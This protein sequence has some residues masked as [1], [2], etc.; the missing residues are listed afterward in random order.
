MLTVFARLSDKQR[1]TRAVVVVM[2]KVFTA[3]PA[4]LAWY[5]DTFKFYTHAHIYAVGHKY[6]PLFNSAIT[7]LN[8]NRSSNKSI[9][10]K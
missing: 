8:G 5:T 10:A 6:E 7:L 4:I 2:G 1:L 3:R 9:T